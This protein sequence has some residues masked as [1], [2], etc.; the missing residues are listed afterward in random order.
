MSYA[1]EEFIKA[2]GRFSGVKVDKATGSKYFTETG[3]GRHIPHRIGIPVETNNKAGKTSRKIVGCFRTF[4]GALA[5]GAAH[6]TQGAFE[7]LR[8]ALCDFYG[9]PRDLQMGATTQMIKADPN[10]DD[11]KAEDGGVPGVEQAD[12][13]KPRKR[14]AKAAAEDGEVTATKGKKKKAPKKKAKKAVIKGSRGFT[15]IKASANPDKASI[16]LLGAADVLKARER[17][18]RRGDGAPLTEVTAD[19]VTYIFQESLSEERQAKL[20]TNPWAGDN[21]IKGEFLVMAHK[22]FSLNYSTAE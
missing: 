11:K 17:M 2:A 21:N 5:W 6:T 20:K 3:T 10:C 15:L 9:Q 19:G 14:K 13:Y 4:S 1:T 12:E 7:E 22:K 16:V 8:N 18:T